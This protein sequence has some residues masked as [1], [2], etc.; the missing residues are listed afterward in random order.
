[1]KYIKRFNEG[2]EHQDE[3]RNA[4]DEF[5][6]I[7]EDEGIE[8]YI[9]NG[10][11]CIVITME[12]GEEEIPTNG[13]RL[14]QQQVSKMRWIMSL[15]KDD[16]Y[17]EYIDRVEELCE[18]FG[19]KILVESV[20]FIFIIGGDRIKYYAFNK[21]IIIEEKEAFWNSPH[22]TIKKALKNV[23]KETKLGLINRTWS[24]IKKKFSL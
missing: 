19:Y 7:L 15:T 17:L 6:Y 16:S 22:T 18:K 11:G 8:L 9:G 14:W 23:E 21:L 2:V 24:K 20:I 5:G 1:M 13:P 4:I 12:Q 10:S 3:L